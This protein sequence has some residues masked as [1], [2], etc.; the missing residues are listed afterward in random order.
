LSCRLVRLVER[1]FTQGVAAI[2]QQPAAGHQDSTDGGAGQLPRL[3]M[4]PVER[5]DA[6]RHGEIERKRDA[7]ALCGQA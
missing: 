6:D 1:D 3:G 7:E 5:P 2:D 4:P